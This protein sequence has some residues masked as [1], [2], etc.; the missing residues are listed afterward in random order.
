MKKP[1]KNIRLNLIEGKTWGKHFYSHIVDFSILSLELGDLD[2]SH[3]ERK[4]LVSLMESSLHHEILDL[5]LSNLSESDKKIFLKN[6][7]SK[8]HDEIWKFLNLKIKNIE[9]KIKKAAEDLKNALHKDIK[10]VRLL[11]NKK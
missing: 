1:V 4:H 6:L 2:L 7:A 9:E 11:S 8:D 10:K 5:V 3:D